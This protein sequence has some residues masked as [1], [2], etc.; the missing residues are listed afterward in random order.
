M[1]TRFFSSLLCFSLSL[2]GVAC[3]ETSLNGSTDFSVE[4]SPRVTVSTPLPMSAP[5][6]QRSINRARTLPSLTEIQVDENFN[7]DMQQLVDVKVV[8]ADPRAKYILYQV[9][10]QQ[11]NSAQ[12]ATFFSKG[13]THIQQKVDRYIQELLLVRVTSE[14]T[15][16]HYGSI[17]NQQ[18]QFDFQSFTTQ[19]FSILSQSEELVIPSDK[20]LLF[21][22]NTAGELGYIDKETL[23]STLLSHLPP[24]VG[25]AITC[26]YD[27]DN[28]RVYMQDR[29]SPFGITYY[30]LHTGEF[31][32]VGSAPGL[33]SSYPWMA[34]NQKDKLLYVG[35]ANQIFVI[36]P[37]TTNTLSTITVDGYSGSTGGGDLDFDSQYKI[38]GAPNSGLYGISAADNVGVPARI[39]GE[40]LPFYITSLA[41]DEKDIVWLATSDNS[42]KLMNMDTVTGDYTVRQTFDH[43]INDLA[44][45]PKNPSNDTL[46]TDGDG[47]RDEDDD[48]PADPEVVSAVYS[49]S[50][51]G[52]GSLAFEDMWPE[53][54]DYDFNDLVVGYRMIKY[55]DANNQAVKMTMKFSVMSIGADLKNGFGIELPIS[56]DLIASVK[57]GKNLNQV[58]QLDDKNLEKGH[59]NAVI[60][61]FDDARE[62]FALPINGMSRTDYS[63][64]EAPLAEIDIE[65]RFTQH[66]DMNLLAGSPYNPFIFSKANRRKEVHL[67][68]Q[69]PTALADQKLFKSQDDNTQLD[70][71]VTYKTTQG[72]PWAINLPHKFRVPL[73]RVS[74]DKAYGKFVSFATSAGAYS[75]WYTDAPGNRTLQNIYLPQSDPALFVD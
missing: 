25:T 44:Y 74:I 33:K 31:K 69:K 32:Q 36:D 6:V 5:L 13:Q 60:I 70:S 30:D 55:V 14:G 20:N 28:E 42:A 10:P 23:S 68:G 75:D 2:F 4:T 48:F 46:D 21:Y 61:V 56:K 57:G 27:A 39:S 18:V 7:F 43:K 59:T 22:T 35:Q 37:S 41:I 63:Q 73:E 19:G 3:T 72:L 9:D 53:K 12:L 54:G 62:N 50:Q 29:V 34:F 16:Y 64:V 26:A 67:P 52:T 45:R 51:F 15:T 17:Q 1:S 24:W 66:I 38:Y 71:G 40:S 47:I 65:I 8:D 58:V 11:K 49:P